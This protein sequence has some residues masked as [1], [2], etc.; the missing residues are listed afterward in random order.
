MIRYDGMRPAPSSN[1]F[2]G[3]ALNFEALAIMEKI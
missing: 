2:G 3:T 1:N